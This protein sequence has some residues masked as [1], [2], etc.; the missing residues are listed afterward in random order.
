MDPYVACTC[1]EGLICYLSSTEGYNVANAI[2]KYFVYVILVKNTEYKFIRSS[3][4]HVLL[5]VSGNRP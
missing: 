1:S 2:L 4:E 5:S 3:Y